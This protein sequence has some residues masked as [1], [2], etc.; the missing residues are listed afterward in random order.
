MYAEKQRENKFLSLSHEDKIKIKQ[1]PIPNISV[2][3]K[4]KFGY[5]DVITS[6]YFVFPAINFKCLNLFLST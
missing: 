5:V 6:M 1:P 3:E 4:T 2:Y